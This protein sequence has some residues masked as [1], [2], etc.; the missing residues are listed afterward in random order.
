MNINEGWINAGK[1]KVF[2]RYA[3]N[4][5]PL[6]L[7]HG[8]YRSSFIWHKNIPGLARH[9][10]V[11]APD[12]PGYGKTYPKV[13]RI[14]PNMVEFAVEFLSA[15]SV[16]S[17]YW[18]GE[19]RSG[20]IC[21]QLASQHPNL[22]QKIVLVSPSGLPPVEIPKP[23]E[24]GRSRWEWFVERSFESQSVVDDEYLRDYI[25]RDMEIAEPY[26]QLR[27]SLLPSSYFEKGLIEEMVRISCPVML[28]WG[29]NDP[30]FPVESILRFKELIPTVEKELIIDN[31]R[32]LPFFEYPQIFN[33]EVTKFLL[34]RHSL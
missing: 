15:I 22:T 4:G 19:S 21:I 17:A 33:V 8:S 32:H 18:V 3:G 7:L 26:E 24:I 31:A 2:F 13:L 20:G 9:F 6:I 29:R 1:W 14:L 16:D 28:V 25:V 5:P 10:S 12:R 23:P 30:V 11:F 27:A 34:D